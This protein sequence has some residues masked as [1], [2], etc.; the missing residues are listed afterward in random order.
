LSGHTSSRP[1]AWSRWRSGNR[2]FCEKVSD[3]QAKVD[4]LDRDDGK[5]DAAVRVQRI[6][7]SILKV[8][9]NN[10][11][12]NSPNYMSIEKVSDKTGHDYDTVVQHA[13]MLSRVEFGGYVQFDRMEDST[14]HPTLEA[15]RDIVHVPPLDTMP[16]VATTLPR[17]EDLDP[18]EC[19][20]PDCSVNEAHLD[21][22]LL[23][24]PRLSGPAIEIISKP[25]MPSHTS[26]STVVPYSRPCRSACLIRRATTTTK[27][28]D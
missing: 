26:V 21:K 17:R 3:L 8:L 10:I 18:F 28:G 14:K 25:V 5:I 24:Y 27:Y 2:E 9:C 13:V 19:L 23:A 22:D 6:E 15:V 20:N 4:K 12:V 11:G 1:S 16:L 7:A